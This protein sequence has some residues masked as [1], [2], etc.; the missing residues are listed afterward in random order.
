VRKPERLPQP[1]VFS[2]ACLTKADGGDT[3]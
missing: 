3:L 2:T 1:F